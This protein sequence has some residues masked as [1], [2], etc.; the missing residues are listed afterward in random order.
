[1]EPPDI[2]DQILASSLSRAASIASRPSS[3]ALT[4]QPKPYRAKALNEQR[5]IALVEEPLKI[6]FRALVRGQER[7]PLFLHG[8]AGTGKT[9]AALALLDHLWPW[10]QAYATTVDLTSAVM[11]SYDKNRPDFDWQQF[12]PY[13]IL[14]DSREDTPSDKRGAALMVLD[15]LGM[16]DKVTDTHYECVKRVLDMRRGQ[17][18]ILVSNH[19][20]KE[21][22]TLY[23]GRIASRCAAGTVV[24]LRGRDRRTL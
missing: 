14:N 13:R 18:L 22:E 1:M 21:I 8:K 3:A 23:D 12:G 4:L 2:F 19:G 15:E 6:V 9:C 24:E 20:L 11:A 5:E 10:Q 7:W 16:R 17:P